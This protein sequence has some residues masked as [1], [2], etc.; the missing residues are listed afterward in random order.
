MMYSLL[1]SY[2]IGTHPSKIMWLELVILEL[3][4]DT[5]LIL[6]CLKSVSGKIILHGQQT[7]VCN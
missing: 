6:T 1:P 5:C 7:I 2:V 3:S 4:A